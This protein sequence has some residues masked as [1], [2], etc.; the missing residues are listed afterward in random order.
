MRLDQIRGHLK[1]VCGDERL[2]VL[3]PDDAQPKSLDRL[4]KEHQERVVWSNF[5]KL[6]NIVAKILE[7]KQSPPSEMEAFLL[8]EF[9]TFLHKEGLAISSKERVMVVSA[10]KAWPRYYNKAVMGDIRKPN[11]NP[12]D[13]LAFY[14]GF[15]IKAFV[16]RIKSA[17]NPINITIDGEVEENLDEHQRQVVRKLLD[18]RYKGE[19]FDEPLMVL[20]VSGPD[21]DDTIKLPNPIEVDSIGKNGKRAALMMGGVRYVTLESL[22]NARYTSDL[23]PC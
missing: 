23:K 14:T 1:A 2:L 7:D 3:T 9:S 18:N 4:S 17:S 22:R 12:S 16:P 13:H 19:E 8:R 11:W 5:S 10:G 20:F 6:D 15:E 21:D